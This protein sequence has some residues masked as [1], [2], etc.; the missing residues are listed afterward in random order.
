ME[1]NGRDK[2]QCGHF[3][4]AWGMRWPPVSCKSRQENH[5]WTSLV[6]MW[7]SCSHTSNMLFCK[8]GWYS[9]IPSA[10]MHLVF[11]GNDLLLKTLP[12]TS[13]PWE[14]FFHSEVRINYLDYGR[15]HWYYI[16]WVS[17]LINSPNLAP[18]YLASYN[19]TWMDSFW[20]CLILY[21]EVCEF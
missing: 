2:G 7:A 13:I 8:P 9:G 20:I 18:M 4:W 21:A 5:P 15:E 14:L 19:S 6:F 16:K 3:G 11:V 1:F 10:P 17:P 12:S